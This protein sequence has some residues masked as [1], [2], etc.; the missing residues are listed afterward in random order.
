MFINICSVKMGS[1]L[2]YPDTEKEIIEK[3]NYKIC[4]MRGWRKT[5]E[6]AEIYIITKKY[7][8]F[9]VCD[10]HGSQTGNV[11]KWLGDHLWKFISEELDSNTNIQDKNSSTELDIITDKIK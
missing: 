3:N 11:S 6:D 5:N 2:T 9:A 1:Y 8:F 4:T 7:K 10:G